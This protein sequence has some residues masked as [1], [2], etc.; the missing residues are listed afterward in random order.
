MRTNIDIDDT[1]M[2]AALAGGEFKTKREVVEEGLRLVARRNH[3]R[4]VL[5]WKGKLHWSDQPDPSGPQPSDNMV[6]ENI[7]PY[8]GFSQHAGR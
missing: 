2:A 5:K 3:Y 4:E 6:S 1:L 8:A 7:V